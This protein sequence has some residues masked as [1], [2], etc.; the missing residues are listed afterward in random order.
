M[1]EIGVVGRGGKC[2]ET[3]DT[4][5]GGL[6]LFDLLV[7]G[8]GTL[9]WSF[10]DCRNALKTEAL[11]TAIGSGSPKVVEFWLTYFAS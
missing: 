2:P 3:G 11:F 6:V 8:L 1:R 4:D 10:F 9:V 7:E 5:P